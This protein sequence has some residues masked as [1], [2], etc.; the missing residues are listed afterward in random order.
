MRAKYDPRELFKR[1]EDRAAKTAE[2]AKDF[3]AEVLD[4]KLDPEAEDF[5]QVSTGRVDA[6]SPRVTSPALPASC[7]ESSSLKGGRCFC[8]EWVRTA[9]SPRPPSQR[10]QR[11]TRRSKRRIRLR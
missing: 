11:W 4:G 9:P 8:R 7:F 3:I 10:T 1:K 6:S 2:L 5:N